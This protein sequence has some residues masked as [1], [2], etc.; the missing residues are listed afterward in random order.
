M[1]E[2]DY[3]IGRYRGERALVYYDAAGKRHRHKL[4][5]ADP[6][7]AERRAPALFAELTR[8]QGSSVAELW[9]AYLADMQG[10]AVVA[11]MRHTYKALAARFGPLPGEAVAIADCRAHIAERRAAGLAEATIHTELGHLRMVLRWAARHGL[12]AAAP[13]IERP[14][15][16]RHRE[17]HL[18]RE[19]VRRLFE[20]AAAPH[21]RLFA[22][23]AYTTA[24]RSAAIC[25]LTWERCDFARGL[26]DLE[27]PEIARPHKGRA[28]VPMLRTARAALLEARAGALSEHVV[29]W[30]GRP[31]KRVRRGLA[32]AGRRAGLSKVTPHMLRHS[33]AVHL[34]EDGVGMEEIAQF[35]GHGDVETTRRVYARFSPAYLARAAGA[36][37]YDDLARLVAA[38]R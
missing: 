15:R 20:G 38:K 30:A 18:S 29:E 22:I 37:E 12:I 1:P 33:A 5:T 14:P 36:L 11:T 35:L 2:R 8:P 23:L 27:D 10:R 9:P 7:E 26:I 32:T 28:V 6:R 16:P 19:A 21:V 3:R 25:G 13:A 31:V 4:D 24:G 34:A 17:R